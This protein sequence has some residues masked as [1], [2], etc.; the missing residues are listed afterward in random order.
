MP[1]QFAITV[2]GREVV[3][4][5]QTSVAVAILRVGDFI[6]I[7]VSGKPR[8]PL[9]AIGVCFECRATVN[10]IE[11]QRTCQMLCEPGMD[12]RRQ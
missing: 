8:G 10:G 9:C 5:H 4:D 2:N 3:T 12:V 11:H 6:R 1:E 7:S